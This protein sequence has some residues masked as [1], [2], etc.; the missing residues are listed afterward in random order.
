MELVAIVFMLGAGGAIAAFAMAAMKIASLEQAGQAR[1]PDR[2]D[3]IAASILVHVVHVGGASFEEATRAV[4]RGSGLAAPVTGGI[5]VASWADSYAVAATPQQRRE[6]LE[7]AVRLVASGGSA[8]P[9]RQY[10]ALLDLSF[11][12]GF[13]TDALARLRQTYGFDYVDHAAD[14][15]PREEVAI[16]LFE[17]SPADRERLLG[18]LELTGDVSRRELTAAYRKVVAR[19]HPDRFHGS[20]AAERELAAERFIAVTRAYEGLLPSCRD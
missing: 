7:T 18:L 4:R 6:L 20:A 9:L 13:Q 16:P 17:R 19:H 2:R 12:L 10:A 5:D 3:A 14:A 8:V 11:G 1:L 15:R